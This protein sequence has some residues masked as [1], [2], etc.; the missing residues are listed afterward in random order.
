[1]TTPERVEEALLRHGLPMK[2]PHPVQNVQMRSDGTPY[3]G[4]IS[5]ARANRRNG[6]GTTARMTKPSAPKAGHRRVRSH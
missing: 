3:P 5:L 2:P 4:Q 1:M 6:L